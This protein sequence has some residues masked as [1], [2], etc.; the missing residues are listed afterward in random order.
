MTQENRELRLT[1]RFT[2]AVEHARQVHQ[3]CR[4]STHVPYLAHP[5]GVASLVMG[6]NG[7]LE[8]G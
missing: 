1:E 6:E 8:R 2:R 4:K 3:E 7:S 5:L